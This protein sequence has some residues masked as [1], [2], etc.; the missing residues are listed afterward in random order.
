MLDLTCVLGVCH[1]KA[2]ILI[3]LKEVL[4][5]LKHVL[6]L[7]LGCAAILAA[8]QP[9]NPVIVVLLLWP[10]HVLQEDI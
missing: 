4:E 6:Q 1:W 9:L 10:F 7:F 3:M 8:A 5:L 2:M